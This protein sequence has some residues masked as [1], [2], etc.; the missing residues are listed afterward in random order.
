MWTWSEALLLV[1]SLVIQGVM[2]LR[3]WESGWCGEAGV[4]KQMQGGRCGEAGMGV[5]HAT[6][7]HTMISKRVWAE[8]HRA[9]KCFLAQSCAAA[10]AQ[11]SVTSSAGDISKD[12]PLK[13]RARLGHW[14][15][16]GWSAAFIYQPSTH[17]LVSKGGLCRCVIKQNLELVEN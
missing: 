14:K 4:R 13:G 8:Q 15:G 9:L 16:L 12:K 2:H 6:R 3:V 10:K 11:P 5:G 17:Q 7:P 1:V